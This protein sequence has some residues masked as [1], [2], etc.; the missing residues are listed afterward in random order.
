[1]SYAWPRYPYQTLIMK[2]WEERWHNSSKL[3]AR[4]QLGLDARVKSLP[5]SSGGT[6]VRHAAS[7]VSREPIKTAGVM[8]RKTHS[9]GIN[10]S[11]MGPARPPTGELQIYGARLRE[12]HVAQS[13]TQTCMRTGSAAS[14]HSPFW[15][16]RG[17]MNIMSLFKPVVLYSS[18]FVIIFPTVVLERKQRSA[19]SYE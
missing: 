8:R 3:G 4:E 6:C 15:G 1:M 5:R 19:E 16:F 7:S 14:S 18:A 9:A 13:R 11:E 10:H 17:R 2:R 12:R